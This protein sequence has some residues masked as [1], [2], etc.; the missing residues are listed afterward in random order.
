LKELIGLIISLNV[1]EEIIICEGGSTDN[2]WDIALELQRSH[3]GLITA[4]KQTGKGKFN[5][6]L[7]ASKVSKSEMILIWDADG[8]VSVEDTRKIIEIART[9]RVF[10]TGNRL[11]GKMEKGAMRFANKLGNWAFAILW[12]PIL[13]RG[14]MDL[15]CGTKIFPREVMETLPQVL[16]D[17]DPYGDFALLS[18][19]K[20]LQ[21]RI[22]SI[23]VDY[24][25]R[26]YGETNI[27][28][29]SGGVNLLMT[30]FKIFLITIKY[31]QMKGRELSS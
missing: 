20:R 29:W 28:R 16:K 30:T 9:N 25:Q 12:I 17:S 24:R 21:I 31:R 13:Q 18:H 2:T 5:A 19:A 1:I 10:A 23:V 8:T 3:P 27:D 26:A 11:L 22:I 15:L 14:P 7:E 4:V 6:V